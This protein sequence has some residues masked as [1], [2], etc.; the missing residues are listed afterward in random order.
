MSDAT[1]PEDDDDLSAAELAL[2]LPEADERE[3]LA[4]R[5]AREPAFAARVARWD[6]RLAPLYDMIAPVAAPAGVWQ[7]VAARIVDPTEALR[8][9]LRRWQWATGVASAM[10]AA[11]AVMLAW[12]TPPVT[13]PAPEVVQVPAPAPMMAVAQLADDRGTPLLAVGIERRS[14]HVSIRLQDLPTAARVPEL[15]VIPEGGAPRSLGLIRADG[16]LDA[17]LPPDVRTIVG[18]KATL[19]VSME[20]PE[21]APHAA[22]AGPIV[23]TGAVVTL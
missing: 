21:G 2:G 18:A 22:P 5:A 14:G 6:A 19:A 3:A 20:L 12:P 15:W 8:V 13:A 9:R 17:V 11:L 16:T 10:A 23:A 7:R 4:A 1:L